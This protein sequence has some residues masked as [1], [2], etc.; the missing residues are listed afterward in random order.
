MFTLYVLFGAGR[1]N[2]GQGQ[3]AR[4]ISLPQVSR[5]QELETY[6]ITITW[7]SSPHCIPSQRETVN[8]HWMNGLTQA[9]S[10]RLGAVT[11]SVKSDTSSLFYR[12]V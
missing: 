1:Q 7:F 12:I 8:T 5:Q 4:I 6:D 11:W 3:S 10:V 9:P 2:G